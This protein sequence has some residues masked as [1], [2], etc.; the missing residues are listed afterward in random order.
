MKKTIVISLGGSVIIPKEGFDLKFL[1]GFKKLILSLIKNYR[2]IIVC[3]GGQ[4]ARSYQQIVRI[5]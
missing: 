2:F 1:K 4:T 5:K 3:G